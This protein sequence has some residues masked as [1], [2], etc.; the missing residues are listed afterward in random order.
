MGYDGG[1]SGVA[2]PGGTV[3]RGPVCPTV[4]LLVPLTVDVYTGKLCAAV[5]ATRVRL[6]KKCAIY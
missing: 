1:P 5:S 6:L 4:V 2:T 3:T